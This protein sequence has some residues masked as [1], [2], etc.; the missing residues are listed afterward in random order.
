MY[1]QTKFGRKRI[2]R[3]I[4]SHILITVIRVLE[5]STTIFLHDTMAY[6]M[7]DTKFGYKKGC[8]SEDI[9]RTHLN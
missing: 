2:R 7:Y 8:H 1:H 3:Y 9:V 6:D 4:E 5:D